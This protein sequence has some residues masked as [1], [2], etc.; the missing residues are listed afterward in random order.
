MRDAR[1]RTE[2]SRGWRTTLVVASVA[3]TMVLGCLA[4]GG[5]QSPA[6]SGNDQK[7]ADPAPKAQAA[8]PAAADE[9]PA[10]AATSTDLPGTFTNSDAGAWGD[11]QYARAVNAG[12]RGCNACHA[13]LFSVLPKG[14]NSKGLHE[15]DKPAAYGRVYTYNDCTTCHI[16]SGAAQNGMNTGGAGPY[17]APSIHGSHFANQTFLAQ[18]G[19]C[20]SCHET[21]VLTGEL[22]M[23][24]ELKYTKS[25]GLGNNA[26]LEVVG[27]WIAGRGYETS[28]VTG[29]MIEHNVKLDNV[30][31]NQDPTESAEDL[32]SATNM[33]YPN[34][35]EADYKVAIKGVKN[36]KTYTL[37]ELRAMPQTEITYTRVCGTNGN[38]GGWYIANIPAKGVLL[39]DIIEDCGGLVDGVDTIASAGYDG[40]AG[41]FTPAPTGLSMEAYLDPNAMIALEQFGEPIE[42]IDGGPAYFVIPGG[43]AFAGSK[44]VNEIS[45]FKGNGTE[46]RSIADWGMATN[47]GS[48][49]TPNIDGTKCKVGEPI[50]LSGVAFSLAEQHDIDMTAIKVSADYGETWTEIP[51]PTN[52]DQD[53]WVKWSATWTPEVAGTYCLTMHVESENP[54][55]ASNDGH[56]IIKVT[57]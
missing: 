14:M 24:D 30:V 51:L 4:L 32:Y 12:N 57:E 41:P 37:D 10:A 7:A 42:L 34:V 1:I 21:D 31:S 9:K 44:W 22:G 16:H 15:V 35:S 33:D 20:F 46:V 43:V 53:Q 27:T 11:T 19:N 25:I 54:D 39:S 29:G 47:T 56:V 23:W 36:E 13:D 5:C 45:F 50:D 8:E 6:P 28:T 18:G 40:W 2:R 3:C 17:M 55:A 49:L 26:A 38:N 48:W 52:M